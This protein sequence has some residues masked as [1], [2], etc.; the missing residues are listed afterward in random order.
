MAF[1]IVDMSVI[2]VRQEPS[3]RGELATQLLFGELYE[4]VETAGKWLRVM[5]LS[6][7][8]E[9]WMEAG[10]HKAVDETYV[11]RYRASDQLVVD[12]V[13]QVVRETGDWESRLVVAGSVLPFYDAYRKTFQ[14]GDAEYSLLGGTREVGLDDV[15]DLLVQYALMYYNT[16]YLWRGRTPYGVDAAGLTRMAYRLAG[17]SLPG[18]VEEQVLQGQP[19]AFVEE[20]LPG[21]LAF[22]GDASGAIS[23]VG[24]LWQPGRII[25]ASGR[26]RVDKLDHH[27]IF[28]E[29]TKRYTHALKLI[30]RYI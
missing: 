24:M 2:P 15:R 5:S 28:N 12:E 16:P 20:A 1:G 26:V 30:K 27:G 25:H 10:R 13:F 19:L 22:F 23:H 14:V 7:G 8:D 18:S 21:D 3:E 4:V 29:T 17:V 11:N 9:G 6:G